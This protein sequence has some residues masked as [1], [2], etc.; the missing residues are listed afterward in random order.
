[1]LTTLRRRL[2]HRRRTEPRAVG[3]LLHHRRRGSCWP[4]RRS[5]AG[6][7]LRAGRRDRRAVTP[8]LPERTAD[9]VS[10]SSRPTGCRRPSWTFH[11]D[12]V[13]AA[14]RPR[15]VRPRPDLALPP[16]PSSDR[17]W[18]TRRRRR[19]PA[20]A[21][22]ARGGHGDVPRGGR[23][24]R[25]PAPSALDRSRRHPHRRVLHR[26]GRPA[27]RPPAGRPRR[28]RDQ[29]RAPGEPG[30]ARLGPQPRPPGW[31][32]GAPA[33]PVRAEVFPDA[34]PGEH[35]GTAWASGTR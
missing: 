12:A 28:R 8:W 14:R 33:P 34:D 10:P 11:D 26:L 20:T 21:V 6:G 23:S 16:A 35:P 13:R 25:R 22:R 9:Q 1:M 4:T 29:G 17:S 3:E 32:W 18:S 30:L 7:P 19:G 15:R 2:D 27:H 5:P 31:T 24:G